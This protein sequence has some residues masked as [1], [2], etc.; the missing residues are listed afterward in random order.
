MD[1]CWDLHIPS[2]GALSPLLSRLKISL[3]IPWYFVTPHVHHQNSWYVIACIEM[4]SNQAPNFSDFHPDEF[5]LSMIHS[6][7][8]HGIKTE[9]SCWL[10]TSI[11]PLA[12]ALVVLMDM[13]LVNYLMDMTSMR[14]EGTKQMKHGSTSALGAAIFSLIDGGRRTHPPSEQFLTAF[15]VKWF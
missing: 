4:K 3:H 8:P 6:Q 11:S 14:V 10:V 7:S 5:W 1:Y 13:K 9:C 15:Q 12:T 2:E